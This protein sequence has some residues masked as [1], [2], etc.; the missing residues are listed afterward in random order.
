METITFELDLQTEYWKDPPRIKILVDNVIK[1]DDEIKT[2]GPVRFTADLAFGAH[3]L[4]IHRTGKTN[5]QVG[6]TV[7]QHVILN[8]V[9]IDGTD[10]RDLVWTRA[11]Y[12]PEYPEPW[13]SQQRQAGIELEQRVLGETCL[14]HNGVWNF[15]FKSP[16]YRYIMDWMG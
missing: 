16:F 11:Y 5:A 1:F 13:A 14:S 10:I 3:L 2:N 4:Q 6:P 8:R 12:V 9:K 15:E 7:G